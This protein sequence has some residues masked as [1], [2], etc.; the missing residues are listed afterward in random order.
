MGNIQFKTLS[1]QIKC[2]WNTDIDSLKEKNVAT[3]LKGETFFYQIVFKGTTS[4][5]DRRI[6]AKIKIESPLKDNIELFSVENVPVR[7]PMYKFCRDEN[8]LSRDPGMYPDVLIPM[9]INER[10]VISSHTLR[11]VFVK[12][13]VPSYFSGGEYPIKISFLSDSDENELFCSEFRL[14]VIPA[15]LPEQKLIYTEW[16]YSDCLADYYNVPVFGEEHWRIIENFMSLATDSGINMIL[17]PL[18]TVPLDT[19]IG[20]ERT[21]TQLIDVYINNGEW[22]FGFDRLDRWIEISKRCGYKYWEMSHLFTQWGAKNAPKIMAYVDGEYK[23][24][25]GWDT[26]SLG[27]EYK[28]FLKNFLTNLCPHLA[29]L[30]LSKDNCFFHASDEPNGEQCD[31]YCE[32][33][34][35]I[36]PYIGEYKIIDAL[37][38]LSL[39]E[40]GAVEHPI[41][42]TNAIEPFRAANIPELWTYFCCAQNTDVANCFIAMPSYRTRIIGTQFYKY[43]IKGFLHWGYN[44]YNSMLS[45]KHINPYICNDG[46]MA[47]PAGDPFLVYPASDGRALPSLR[48]VYMKEAIQDT[49]ALSLAEELCGRDAVIE[50]I[51]GNLKEKISFSQYPMSSN[52]ILDLREKINA[53]IAEASI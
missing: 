44:F 27:V 6:T 13:S 15:I 7:Y 38:D 50:A 19:E 10:A 45:I 31:R 43:N 20:G 23:Q 25:F 9:E 47:V 24:I 53:M 32:I 8:Y 29:L 11:S 16:F 52:Y 46:D 34:K 3:A 12:V 5:F 51:E 2:F 21:T 49:R 28:D 17:T 42:A 30:G 26:D 14:T 35:A 41:P 37:S 1:S 33:C 39:Y 36:K 4:A 48:L 40:N 18:F 22:S